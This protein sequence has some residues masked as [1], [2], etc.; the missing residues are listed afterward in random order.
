MLMFDVIMNH[1]L[2]VRHSAT[3]CVSED[4]VWHQYLEWDHVSAH[5]LLIQSENH[6]VKRYHSGS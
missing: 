6:S 5:L 4:E 1:H 3:T 2:L